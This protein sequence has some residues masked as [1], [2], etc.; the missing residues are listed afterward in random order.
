MKTNK[1]LLVLIALLLAAILGV[2]VYQM[3]QPKTPGE[4]LE[5]ALNNAGDDIGEA[6]EDLG[7][8]IQKESR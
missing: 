3:N 6:L 8:D 7:K 1:T 5:R 2:L 4:K